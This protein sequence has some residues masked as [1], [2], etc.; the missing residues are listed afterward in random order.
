MVWVSFDPLR[1]LGFPDTRFLKPAQLYSQQE[2]LKQADRV[3]FPEYWQLG[4]LLY[5]M[6]RKIFPSLP[7]Y[8]IGHDKIEMT[9]A[10]TA[11]VPNHVPETHIAANTPEKAAELW[12]LMSLP[13]V[14][15]IPRSAQGSGVWLVTSRAEWRAYLAATEVL[16]VQEYLPID[17]DLRVVVVGSEIIAAYWRLQS[18]DGFHNNLSRGGVLDYG[19]V[20]ETALQLVRDTA[21]QLGI[22]HA[23]FDV[24][25][26]GNHP[27]LLEFNRL[28][29][30]AG[31]PGGDQAVRTA[32]LN[33]L[34]LD[35]LAVPPT[36]S[37][38]EGMPRPAE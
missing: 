15:K 7:S 9:R 37:R 1:T 19:P 4:A 14:A 24:A 27:F 6:Q 29:G 12:E 10:F 20:P 17:R 3:L 30:T 31:I 23:G 38:D 21:R 8:L 28:F 35:F 25:M 16:Y 22:D 36:G 11:V 26:V 32:I 18:G 33:Y 13:F 2:L 34:S 5:G